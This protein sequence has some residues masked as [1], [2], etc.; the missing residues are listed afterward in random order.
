MPIQH[1]S[2]LVSRRV[3]LSIIMIGVTWVLQTVIFEV[4]VMPI[5]QVSTLTGHMVDKFRDWSNSFCAT[6]AK[7][8]LSSI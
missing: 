4:G 6:V 2:S 3:D 1:I 8:H 5:Q 7:S